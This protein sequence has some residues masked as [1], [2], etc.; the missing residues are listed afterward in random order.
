MTPARQALLTRLAGPVARRLP[1][2]DRQLAES[3][4]RDVMTATDASRAER[5]ANIRPVQKHVPAPPPGMHLPSKGIRSHRGPTWLD[6][7][8]PGKATRK[9]KPPVAKKKTSKV[10]TET[11]VALFGDK[12]WWQ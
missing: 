11:D 1:A 3:I 10:L 8:Q 7:P 6:S 12:P 9:G 2:Q 4:A 5:E